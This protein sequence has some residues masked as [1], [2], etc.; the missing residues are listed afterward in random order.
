MNYDWKEFNT[1]SIEV[2]KHQQSINCPV[3]KETLIRNAISR[4]FYHAYHCINNWAH[5]CLQY[6]RER[7]PKKPTHQGLI[8]FLT[9][10]G[11]TYSTLVQQYTS[12]KKIRSKADYSQ[13][14]EKLDDLLR[15]A[16]AI[17]N[18]IIQQYG[19]FSKKQ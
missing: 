7:D 1:F 6:D 3:S 10:K 9:G 13:S 2:L 12:I 11:A 4:L 16:Q 8:D 17:H 15:E 14:I 19:H 18:D 5:D